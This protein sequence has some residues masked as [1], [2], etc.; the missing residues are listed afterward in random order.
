M[1]NRDYQFSFQEI[2]DSREQI[3]EVIEGRLRTAVL[4]MVYEL[5][6]QEVSSL[7]GPKYS[8]DSEAVRNGSDPGSVILQGQRVSVRKPRVK[9]AGKDVKLESYSAL[10]E[11]DMLC[12]RVREH[13]IRG[14]STRDYE[15]LLEEISESSGLKKS[16][17]SK[18]FVRASKG[19]LDEFNSRDLSEHQFASLMIDGVGFGDRTVVVAMG[20]KVTGEKMILGLREGNTEN[21][22]LCRDLFES[23]ISRGLNENQDYL[24]VIDGSKAL[25][26]A[27][28][29][30]F[31]KDSAVQRCVRHKERNICKY[32]PKEYHSECRR[33][34]KRLHGSASADI[35]N[36]EYD[37]L[38][39][40]LGRINHAAL[41]SLEEACKE[42]M[43]VIEL[44][45]PPLLKKTLLSTNPIE[46]AFS[47]TDYRVSR[48]KNWKSG[49]DQVSRWAAT[50]L[51]NVEPRFQKIRGALHLPKLIERLQERK[52][53]LEHQKDVA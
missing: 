43:T 29:K 31:G 15:P 27:I 37:E 4:D 2:K 30:V 21:W 12:E 23:L 13:M 47:Y 34:W 11:Y 33:R 24:F 45:I 39:F 49:S 48:V 8:R 36:N 38:V 28:N 41:E 9:R 18:A 53:K 26:K 16:S 7:C 17:V 46:S 10:R 32:L 52:T 19:A 20:I 44:N 1:K 25:R 6:D 14:V 51:L 50:V 40:W 3:R 42:T 35:A 22:E 5:F